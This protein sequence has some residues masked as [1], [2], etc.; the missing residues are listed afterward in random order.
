MLETIT[1]LNDSREF[2]PRKT[3][4]L[5]SHLFESGVLEVLRWVAGARNLTDALT[6]RS[7]NM[8]AEL[9]K[10]METGLRRLKFCG[11]SRLDRREWR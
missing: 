1:K 3:V 7:P 11:T 8:A 4:A 9:D 6:K 2:R 10:V 5:M